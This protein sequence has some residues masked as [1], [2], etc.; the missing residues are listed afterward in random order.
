MRHQLREDERR[1]AREGT[2]AVLSYYGS[3]IA[4]MALYTVLHSTPTEYVS[5]GTAPQTQVAAIPAPGAF[6]R[7]LSLR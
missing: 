6:E 1:Y 7:G 5:A 3:I 4:V 2:I